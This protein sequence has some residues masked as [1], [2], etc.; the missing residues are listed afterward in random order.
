MKRLILLITIILFPAS[1]LAGEIAVISRK[2]IMPYEEVIGGFERCLSHPVKKYYLPDNVTMKVKFINRLKSNKPYLILAIGE[3]SLNFAIENF[4]NIPIVYT[5]VF[6]P[7]SLIFKDYKHTT[8]I[9]M[10]VDAK[11]KF[12]ILKQIIPKSR[13][14][15]VIYNP[16]ETGKL[17]K[18]AK[19]DADE[20]GMEL[21]ALPISASADVFTT[22][23]SLED[24]VDAF[25]M[26]LDRTVLSQQA[27]EHMLLFSFRHKIPLIG[28]SEK[29]VELGALFALSFENKDMGEQACKLAIDILNGKTPSS[30]VICT[31]K[32]KLSINEKIAHKINIEIPDEIRRQAYRI[33][34]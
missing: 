8:G 27:I 9:C 23:N 20:L 21:V 4:K 3:S 18:K 19:L 14:I 25:W 5:M 10:E 11:Y 2:G 13:K 16:S 33:Y 1:L 6:N 29:Y 28:L 12:E 17:I 22:I 31:S 32:W 24:K 26:R 15:G 7:F 30:S 34:E